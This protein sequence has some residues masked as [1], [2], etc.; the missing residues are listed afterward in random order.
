MPPLVLPAES[1]EMILPRNYFDQ[2]EYQ[3]FILRLRSHATKSG[4]EEAQGFFA[5]PYS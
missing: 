4:L 5:S 3:R 2:R 1:F